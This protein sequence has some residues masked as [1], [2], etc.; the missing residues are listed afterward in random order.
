MTEINTKLSIEKQVYSITEELKE[1]IQ[2]PNDRNRLAYC[3]YKYVKGEGDSPEIL[4]K[5]TKI[6][7]TGITEK[8]LVSKL[9]EAITTVIK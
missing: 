4:V 6:N 1:Y 8:E 5:S 7:F 3:L 9:N 2:L